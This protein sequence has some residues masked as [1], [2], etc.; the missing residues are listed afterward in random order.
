M[1]SLTK[2]ALEEFDNTHDFERMCA[3]VLNSLGYQHVTPIAPKGGGDGGKDIEY[4]IGDTQKGL[5]CISL[6]EGY[7]AKFISDLDKHKKGDYDEYILFSNQYI[8][9]KNKL[10]ITKHCLQSLDARCE[11]KDIEGLRSLLDT[12]LQNVREAYLDIKVEESVVFSFKPT[13]IM[14][15]QLDKYVVGRVRQ[16]IESIKN[17]P[18]ISNSPFSAMISYDKSKEEKVRLLTGYLRQIIT[19]EKNITNKFSFNIEVS[20]TI[21]NDDVE[22]RVRSKDDTVRFSFDDEEVE[23]EERPNLSNNF[24]APYSRVHHIA[25]VFSRNDNDFYATL[26]DDNKTIQCNIRTLNAEQPK[27]LF[28]CTTYILAASPLEEIELQIDIFSSK[29][30]TKLSY[31]LTINLTAGINKVVSE[32]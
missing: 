3:D 13:S 16:E 19:F 17:T 9:A 26:I 14:R 30:K 10:E 15:Y 7:K 22:I 23:L 5:A 6:E 4:K 28:D 8:T 20:S 24:L 18:D 25:P 29:L 21:K 1:L 31:E 11:I 2:K 27:L 32:E 12:A